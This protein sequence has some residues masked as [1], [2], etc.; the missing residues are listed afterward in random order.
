MVG[1]ND[2]K[3]HEGTSISGIE[4]MRAGHFTHTM[5]TLHGGTSQIGLNNLVF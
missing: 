4:H 1:F 2:S 3:L 5:Y